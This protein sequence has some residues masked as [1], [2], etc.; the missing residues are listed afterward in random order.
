M[1]ALACPLVLRHSASAMPLQRSCGSR[2]QLARRAL[3]VPRAQDAGRAGF[4]SFHNGT[5]QVGFGVPAPSLPAATERPVV[6]AAAAAGE[7]APAA[8]A[9]AAPAVAAPAK[10][11]PSKPRLPALDSLRFFLI[12]YIGVGHFVSFATKDAFLLKLLTQVGFF[13]KHCLQPRGEDGPREGRQREGRRGGGH[14]GPGVD[15][16]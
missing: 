13:W 1:A 10:K 6:A 5:A 16:G 14:P 4:A 9:A 8:A 7:P 2:S 15:A 11:A 3:L 12:A